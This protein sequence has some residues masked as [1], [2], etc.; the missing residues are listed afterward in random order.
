MR[1]ARQI[2]RMIWELLIL[3]AF[4]GLA[5]LARRIPPEQIFPTPT[6]THTP[7]PAWIP[8][9]ATQISEAIK[10]NTNKCRARSSIPV[11]GLGA[12][13]DAG[14]EFFDG[15]DASRAA[16]YR[17]IVSLMSDEIGAQ[18]ENAAAYRRRALAYL[19]LGNISAALEDSE[20][21]MEL[22]PDNPRSP[23]IRGVISFALDDHERAIRDWKAVLKLDPCI[24]EVYYRLAEAYDELGDPYK[25]LQYYEF[26]LQIDPDDARSWLGVARLSLDLGRSLACFQNSSTAIELVENRNGSTDF[27][28][29]G[30]AYF[31]RGQCRS[32]LNLH[33]DAVNDFDRYLA[34]RADDP[35]AWLLRGE[36]HRS[37]TAYDAA[38]D[39]FRR[40]IN[41]D[42]EQVEAYLQRGRLEIDLGWWN[43]AL[44]D[45]EHV[46]ALHEVP[47]AYLGRGD[48]RMFLGE[49]DAAISD[50][51]QVTKMVPSYVDG[52]VHLARA[53]STAGRDSETV[54]SATL[55]LELGP[56]EAVAAEMLTLRAVSLTHLH[57]YEQAIVDI[58]G[59]LEAEN[60]PIEWYYYRAVI[61]QGMVRFS[62]AI[63]DLEY[64]LEN[65]PDDAVDL[66]SDAQKRLRLLQP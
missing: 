38:L 7:R 65:V 42:P 10:I 33:Q 18:P 24:A 45:F 39:D 19:R 60:P 51:R 56:D 41:L 6:I 46:L 29:L 49:L 1:A 30:L 62:E 27:S 12:E 63:E 17:A 35:H 54:E 32:F 58:D 16:E 43:A 57:R 14:L 4:L 50:Y 55:A 28:D 66:I 31:I 22:D 48:V 23:M 61:L 20:R 5:A 15:V 2:K 47:R 8:P 9:A 36:A 52:H 44:E 40:S 37:L 11:T 26:A 3:A 21:S 59:A 13:M 64:F 34:D 25:A 53:F